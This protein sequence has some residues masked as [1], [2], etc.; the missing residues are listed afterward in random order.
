MLSVVLIF[1]KS[2]HLSLSKNN[3]YKVLVG[4]LVIM[5]IGTV[6]FYH[7]EQPNIEGLSF[8]DSLWWSFVTVTT[9]GYGDYFPVS[10][11]GRIVAVIL[12]IS[13]IGAFGFVTAAV[14]SAFVEINVKRRMGL[15]KLDLNKHI[16]IV[17]WNKRCLNIIEELVR[18]MPEKKIVVIDE[19]D[20]M[21]TEYKQVHFVRGKGTED[22]VLEKA[23]VKKASLAIVLANEKGE[24]EEGADARAVMVC[25]AI[26]HL[27]P[28][29]HLVAEVLNDE[30]LPHF[31]RANVDEVFVS[32]MV[33]S[34]LLV[35]GALYP[36]VSHTVNELLTNSRGSE[37]YEV[38]L[39]EDYEGMKFAELVNRFIQE[40]KG[41]P[42]GIA[43]NK[44]TY[45][46]P[47][48]DYEI[49]KGDIV[50]YIGQK[51]HRL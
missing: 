20:N 19:I 43:N 26:N 38:P 46:N 13:G 31:K 18:E 25:L 39:P 27:N 12:M 42:I 15:L 2:L 4:M 22:S 16:I 9:V 14:A 49:Q 10:L 48:K 1:F 5:L 50:I 8:W 28:N 3:V 33:S 21:E 6:C 45:V 29:L 32:S 35:R 24:G 44:S 30:H 7:T 51:A 36:R 23:A 34:K 47:E 40:G 41:I 37:F 17:G 11:V